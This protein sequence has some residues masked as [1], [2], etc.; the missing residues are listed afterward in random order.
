MLTKSLLLK[1]FSAADM[2]RWNDKICPVELRELDKQAHKMVAIYFLGKLE[3]AAGSR[4]DWARLIEGGIFEFLQRLV[5]TDLKPQ[6]YHRIR[7]DKARYKALNDWVYANLRTTLAPL[8]QDFARRFKQYFTEEGERAGLERRIIAAAHYYSTTWE[9]D[10]LARSNPEGY[11]IGEIKKSFQREQ[12]RYIGLKSFRALV[13]SRRYRDFLDLV[14]ELRF[15]V[16]WSHLNMDPRVSVLGHMLLVAI[17]SYFFSQQIGAKPSRNYRNFFTGLF[18]DLPEVLTRDII[19]PVKTSFQG[20][21]A[22]VKDYEKEEMARK[23][24]RPG[25]IPKTWQAEM[26]MFTEEEFTDLKDPL[27]MRDGSLVRAADRLAAFVEAYLMIKN[28]SV[29]EELRRAQANLK[30]EYR[31]KV[32]AGVDIGRIIHS[33][34]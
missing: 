15:Q 29:S 6:I 27:F 5:V 1:L 22:M 33:F 18:H 32:V 16:R 30:K 9:F 28:G 8:G 34:N 11:E 23:I 21:A 20:M 25:L 26:K 24:Y 7:Q 4:V 31:R 2:R 12:A 13:R 14:G 10:I 19:N 17:I 3:E